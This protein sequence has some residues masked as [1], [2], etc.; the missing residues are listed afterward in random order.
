MW[1]WIIW[2][3]S[4][5]PHYHFLE[6][7]IHTFHKCSLRGCC[8]MWCCLRIGALMYIFLMLKS[9]NNVG[10][11][12][13]AHH[14]I[15]TTYK[16]SSPK[17][18][19]TREKPTCSHL[20][21]ESRMEFLQRNIRS[22]CQ[23]SLLDNVDT[24]HSWRFLHC[25]SAQTAHRNP[26]TESC[27]LAILGCSQPQVLGLKQMSLTCICIWNGLKTMCPEEEIEKWGWGGIPSSSD[28][29]SFKLLSK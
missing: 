29:S 20:Q 9:E 17:A 8:T 1:N 28:A 10:W 14:D 27:S 6:G 2:F 15:I 24:P 11:C 13:I 16:R 22:L 7:S 25:Y 23:R 21:D 18:N 19:N 12:I 3:F 5:W 26:R 4:D